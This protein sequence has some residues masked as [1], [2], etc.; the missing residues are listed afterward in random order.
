MI[1]P[2]VKSE[3]SK[4]SKK[5]KGLVVFLLLAIGLYFARGLI[6]RTLLVAYLEYH[7]GFRIQAG[8]V[9]VANGI[10]YLE[11]EDVVFRKKESLEPVLRISHIAADVG[12]MGLARRPLRLN[13]LEVVVDYLN[14]ERDK[15]GHTRLAS[16]KTAPAVQSA[17]SPSSTTPRPKSAEGEEA[18]E[19]QFHLDKIKIEVHQ[20]VYTDYSMG[21]TPMEMKL[22]LNLQREYSDVTSADDLAK[23]MSEDLV[24]SLLGDNRDFF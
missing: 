10:R 17:T 11:L 3:K 6:G 9:R 4:V 21:S 5:V 12:F 24:G 23:R 14:L 15:K 16:T 2:M 20:V 18:E 19:I 8:D 13:S 1:S 7:T 22:D